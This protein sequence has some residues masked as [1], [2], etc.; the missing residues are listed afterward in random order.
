MPQVLRQQCGWLLTLVTSRRSTAAF[1]CGERELP[2]YCRRSRCLGFNGWYLSRPVAR[3]GLCGQLLGL[4]CRSR[5]PACARARGVG[6][7]R[8]SRRYP[9]VQR[10]GRG[11]RA[12]HRACAGR[13]NTDHRVFVAVPYYDP[14][15]ESIAFGRALTTPADFGGRDLGWTRAPNNRVLQEAGVHRAVSDS[16]RC[17]SRNFFSSSCAFSIVAK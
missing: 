16:C 3:D 5:P 8:Q 4:C 7:A 10:G 1:R 13:D 15:Q 12:L 14:D 11:V 9:A 2:T 6:N 17:C